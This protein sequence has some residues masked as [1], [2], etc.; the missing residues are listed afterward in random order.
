MEAE[1]T[2]PRPCSDTGSLWGLRLVP[3]PAPAPAPVSH[4]CIKQRLSA[5]EGSRSLSH[6]FDLKTSSPPTDPRGSLREEEGKLK[7]D[8][9]SFP[10]P[11]HT[12][13]Q[14]FRPKEA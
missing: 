4:M 7:A 6:D 3:A 13:H 8:H 11:G 1:D 9:S 2:G 12:K 5:P 10:G 14:V